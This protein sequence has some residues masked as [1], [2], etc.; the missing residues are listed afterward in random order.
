MDL[1]LMWDLFT[2]VMDA[3]AA[4]GIDQDFRTEVE[5]ARERLAPYRVAPDGA[6]QEWSHA[7]PAAEPQHR[8]FSHLFGLFP[9]RQLLAGTP[10]FAAAR[11]SLELRGDAGTGWSLAWKVC[12]WARLHDGDRAHRLISNML[13]LVDPFAHGQGGGVYAN[14]FDAHPPFQID[15]NFGVTA[16][17]AEMLVQSHAGDLHLLP[18]LPSAWPAGRLTGLRARGG[19]EVD[20]EWKGGRLTR[21]RI[22]SHLGGVCRVRSAV[23]LKVDGAPAREP[24]G[25]NPNP[26]FRVHATVAAPGTVVEFETRPRQESNLATA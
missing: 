12:A 15:G 11:R 9:G 7:F 26:F 17:I 3:A 2:N 14:L 4:L 18:A 22:R 5:R 6:L 20:V 21:G 1:A 13:R 23:P 25:P 24:R 8:H 19:F 10:L 16:G